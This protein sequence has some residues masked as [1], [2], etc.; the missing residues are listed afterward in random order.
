MHIVYRIACYFALPLSLFDTF[1]ST[2]F[3]STLSQHSKILAVETLILLHPFL[4]TTIC[5]TK[6]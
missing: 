4:L 1:L 5:L 3:L 2:P 6:R